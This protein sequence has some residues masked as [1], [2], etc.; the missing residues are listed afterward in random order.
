MVNNMQR[1]VVLQEL[2]PVPANIDLNDANDAYL[3][4]MALSS[5]AD[6][7]VTGDGRA[8]LLQRTAIG[9][10]RIVTPSVFCTQAL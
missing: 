2:Q 8:G 9:R 5:E 6:Y 10:T 1:A 3:I 7:L 4:A